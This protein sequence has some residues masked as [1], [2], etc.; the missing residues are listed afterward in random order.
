MLEDAGFKGR[1]R[2]VPQDDEG[3]DVDYLRQELTRAEVLASSGPIIDPTSKPSPEYPKIYRH[4]IYAVPTFSNPT[5][6]TMSLDRRQRLVRVAREFNALI[7]TN[8]VYDF[9]QWAANPYQT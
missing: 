6:L 1:L 3:M 8:N 5:S 9:L 7:I 2:V 4:L